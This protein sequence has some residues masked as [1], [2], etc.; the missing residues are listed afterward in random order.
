MRDVRVCLKCHSGRA[1]RDL[2]CLQ[3]LPHSRYIIFVQ[4]LCACSLLI[5]TY[6]CLNELYR[7]DSDG[8]SHQ[9]IHMNTFLTFKTQFLSNC[10]FLPGGLSLPSTCA[11]LQSVIR[12]TPPARPLP[13]HTH[14]WEETSDA[15]SWPPHCALG[16][17]NE[18]SEKTEK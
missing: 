16:S 18:M 7:E 6:W 4:W 1:S 12:D 17:L 14:T 5:V 11:A 10:P 2:K 8:A 9:C 3:G 13:S 15:W